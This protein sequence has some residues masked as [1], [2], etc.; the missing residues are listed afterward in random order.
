MKWTGKCFM[1]TTN[2]STQILCSNQQPN[3]HRTATQQQNIRVAKGDN[4]PSQYNRDVQQLI[5][6]SKA[7]CIIFN[8]QGD[9][10]SKL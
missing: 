4:Q 1:T 8:K 10:S 6:Q 7:R 5:K 3:F 2:K 9:S